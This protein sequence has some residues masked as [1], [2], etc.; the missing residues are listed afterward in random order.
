MVVCQVCMDLDYDKMQETD[1]VTEKILG[2]VLQ[3][4]LLNLERSAGQGCHTCTIL[5]DGI[6][7]VCPNSRQTNLESPPI[8]IR[9]RRGRSLELRIGDVV[10]CDTIE[11]YTHLGNMMENTFEPG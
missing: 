4:T 3:T 10:D 1:R 2:R 7:V 5:R 8:V 11:F 9:Q 6:R